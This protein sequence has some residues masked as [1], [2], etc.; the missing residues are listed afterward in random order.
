MPVDFVARWLSFL[1][2]LILNAAHAD[3]DYRDEVDIVALRVGLVTLIGVLFLLPTL[4][5]VLPGT[6]DLLSGNADAPTWFCAWCPWACCWRWR[7]V[8]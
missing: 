3:N 5:N 6:S 2:R 7:S 1:G 8:S 4:A